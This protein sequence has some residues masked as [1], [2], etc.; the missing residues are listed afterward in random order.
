M[1]MSR[2][3][4]RDQFEV[5]GDSSIIHRPSGMQ[6]T[7]LPGEDLDGLRVDVSRGASKPMR[8]SADEYDSDTI[9]ALAEEILR[10]VGQR[11]H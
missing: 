4:T 7:K 9:K 6:F 5:T 10:E 8:S 11:D 2:Q 3:V 1:A